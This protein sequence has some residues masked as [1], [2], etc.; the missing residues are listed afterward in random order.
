MARRN[1][2][3]GEKTWREE[4]NGEGTPVELA[5]YLLFIASLL[6]K[7]TWESMKLSCKKQSLSV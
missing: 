7:L 4:I 3:T 5:L 2:L 1:E 6:T